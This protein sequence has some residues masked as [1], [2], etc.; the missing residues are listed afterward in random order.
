MP[1]VN[2]SN[3]TVKELRASLS[4]LSLST[5]G[6][7]SELIQRLQ[8]ASASKVPSLLP[9]DARCVPSNKE[10]HGIGLQK[11]PSLQLDEAQRVPAN[12]EEKGTVAEEAKEEPPTLSKAQ[13][14]GMK[15]K[16]LRD[17]LLARGL[18]TGGLK[19]V[20]AHRLLEAIGKA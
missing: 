15:V 1:E 8:D 18:N 5:S 16:D 2:L 17:A 9:D 6:K 3:L 19:A 20:L 10:A 7:K 12:E 4:A 13:V 14:E 11:L